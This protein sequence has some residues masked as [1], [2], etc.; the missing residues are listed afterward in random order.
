MLSNII[1]SP[2]GLMP[3][4]KSEKPLRKIGALMKEYEADKR[5]IDLLDEN[6]EPYGTL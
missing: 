6:T 3:L 5:I 4:L 2:D 1:I